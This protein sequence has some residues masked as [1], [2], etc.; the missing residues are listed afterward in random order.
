[1]DGT[2]QAESELGV[3]SAFALD[4]RAAGNGGLVVERVLEHRPH[5]RL[6]SAIQGGAAWSWLATTA[7]M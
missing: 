5:A 7:R 2:L 3:G 1:M 6:L 4:A